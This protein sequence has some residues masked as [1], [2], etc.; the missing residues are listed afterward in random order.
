MPGVD[1]AWAGLL[2]LG[3][4]LLVGCARSPEAQKTRL[5]ERGDPYAAMSST[6][7]P[8]S[9]L[10]CARLDRDDARTTRQLAIA[11]YQLGELAQAYCY[12]RRP[13]SRL[14]TIPSSG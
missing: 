1:A 4:L 6:G 14:L 13:R 10:E 3:L 8:L 9:I 11:H 5:L 7:K 12:L 2:V